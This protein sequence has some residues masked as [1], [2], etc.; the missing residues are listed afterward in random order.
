LTINWGDGTDEIIPRTLKL[1]LEQYES[2]LNEYIAQH[3][4]PGPGN[5]IISVSDS[6]RT[7]GIVNIPNSGNTGY[8]LQADLDIN[9]MLGINNS[10]S[11][12]N[13]P[14]D[15][16]MDLDSPFVFDAGAFDND[17][18]SI[19]YKLAPCGGSNLTGYTYPQASNIFSLDSL[20]GLVTWDSPVFCGDYNI[21]ILTEE[22]RQG[23]LIGSVTREIRFKVCFQN[24]LTDYNNPIPFDLFPNPSQESITIEAKGDEKNV[25]EIIDFSGKTVFRT[26]L[27]GKMNIKIDELSNGI[28]LLRLISKKNIQT[29]KFVK[30]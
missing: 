19:S 13:F 28:Y 18:D 7:D 5:Y 12:I 10:V 9:P 3:S 29:R 27:A 20:T 22:W 30:E 11:F 17:G 1:Y 2:N 15:W 21:A 4:Y 8:Y 16:A 24:D 26:T 6:F 25:I 23:T 14:F